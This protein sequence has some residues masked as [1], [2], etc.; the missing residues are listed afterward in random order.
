[1]TKLSEVALN[2]LFERYQLLPNERVYHGK[3]SYDIGV[4]LQGVKEAY[5][6][7]NEKKYLNYLKETLDF[8]IQEDGTI[9]NYDFDAMNIDHINNGKLLFLLYQETGEEKYRQALDLLYLQLEKMPRTSE[10]GFWH[11]KIY[12][13]QMWLDGLYMGAPFLAEY[14]LTFADG[15]GLTEV[16]KQFRICYQHTV[17]AQSGLL[18]H[19]W[20]EKKVQ[21]WADP[22]TGCSANFWGRSMGWF[23]MALIDTIALIESPAL[24]EELQTMFHR[25]L[26]ALAKVRDKEKKVWYQVL[27]K[28]QQHGNYLEASASSMICY[29][30]AKARNIG[31]LDESWDL[32]IQETYQGII[33]EFV[34]ITANGWLNLTRNCQV[35]G[36][37]GADKRDGSF[38]Y[39]IS[40]PIITNDFKGYGAFLQASLLLEPLSMEG[41]KNG[42]TH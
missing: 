37:G 42:K 8:Y 18:Y 4:V 1:M 32:F 10:G 2:T 14:L 39:Y 22:Q 31:V 30:A 25:C 26:Q 21:F 28:G 36:L 16:I 35:A 19:A 34:F 24:T 9:K 38:V 15:Q 29:A 17:D 7:T 41:D 11:K 12:P 20:D 6:Q 5:L 3:W 23:M 33:D 27:D 40:E 13:H